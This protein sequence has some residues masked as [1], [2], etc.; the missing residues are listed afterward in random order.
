MKVLLI[1]NCYRFRGGEEAAV[2]LT[3]SLLKRRG[4]H[5]CTFLHDSR[6]L[7]RSVLGKLQ[8]FATGIYSPSAYKFAWKLIKREKPDI[9]HLH[10]LYPLFSPSVLVA[11]RRA[12][13]PAVMTCH[14]YRL[15]CPTGL[16]LNGHSICERCI[17][18]RE[19][20]CVLKNCTGEIF[21]SVA[22]ALRSSIARQ[23]QLFQKNVTLFI[24]L[25]EFAKVRLVDNGFECDRIVVL[26]NML[27][28]VDSSVDP[29][30]GWYI[31]FAGRINPE[32]GIDTLLAAVAL[33]P[34]ISVRLAGDGP[35]MRSFIESA[36]PNVEFLGRL[37]PQEMAEFYRSAR[38]L[39]LPSKCFEGCPMVIFEAMGY[40]LPIIASR[41]GGLSELVEDGITGFLF[42]PGNSDDLAKKI[43]L[44][45]E[46]PDLCRQMGKAGREKAIREYGEDVYYNRLM[47]V[48][49]RAI[50]LE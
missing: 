30:G 49:E 38:F 21:K 48:Y 22:Y 43:K 2:E 8:A 11:C 12:G 44:L 24:A 14:N 9:V 23:L 18:G 10:N 41:I 26:P 32:K 6:A 31:A 16:H 7:G 47:L 28:A 1:H 13:V 35:I 45:W 33:F 36:T 5:V 39:V 46:N 40:G 50:S 20:W 34:E 4:V 3:I 25:T 27:A 37:E 15:T 17:G 29:S 42:E 19:H